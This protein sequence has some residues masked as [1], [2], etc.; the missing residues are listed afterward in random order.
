MKNSGETGE[1][2][3]KSLIFDKLGINQGMVIENVVAQMLKANEYDLYFHEFMNK[4]EKSKEKKYEI[5]FL[6]V[7]KRKLCP[8]EVKSSGYKSHR[9]FNLFLH[10]YP[11]K[12]EDKYIIYTKDAQSEDGIL[13]IPL[14]MTMCI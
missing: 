12:I 7:K 5:D 13:Y 3:Y 10:K 1:D 14:Y 11:I 2:I 6:L 8:I 9:S 4:E